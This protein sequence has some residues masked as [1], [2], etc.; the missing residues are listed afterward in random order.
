MMR[1]ILNNQYN[2]ICWDTESGLAPEAL[3]QE[4]FDLEK[5]FEN[6]S[7]SFIKAKTFELLLEK[8]QIAVL[9]E[10]I[11]QEKLNACHIMIRQ[12]LRWWNEASENFK[13]MSVDI[14]KARETKTFTC[15]EDFSHTSSNT[16]MLVDLGFCGLIQKLEDAESK[17]DDITEK[18]KDFYHSSKIAISA[19]QSFCKR[20]SLADGITEENARCLKNISEQAPS[21]FY[22]ALQLI[23]VY[24]YLHEYIAGTR[25]RTLGRLD[26]VLYQTYRKDIDSG[27]LSRESAKECLKYFLNKFWTMKVSY[28][29]PFCLGGIGADGEEITN[30]LSYL[31]VEAYNELNIHS[32]KIHIRVSE[33]TPNSFI[34]LVL[35]CIRGG[36]SSFVFVN[37]AITIKAMMKCGA[38]LEEARNYV[39]IGC[40]E[41]AIFDLEL[42]CTGNGGI[43]LPKMIELVF[44]NGRDFATGELVGV[45]TGSINSYEDFISALKEQ[46][47]YCINKALTYIS[48]VEKYYMQANPDPIL[49]AMLSPC[50]KKGT[51]AYDGG[52]K[53]NNSSYYIHSIATFAD[54]VAAVKKL[55]FDEKRVTFDELGNI[56]KSNWQGHEK[57]RIQMAN[58]NQKY[59]NNIDS[60]DD[61]AVEFA[62]FCAKLI[63]GRANGRGGIFKATNSTTDLCF[64]Y[65]EKTMA[66]PDGRYAGE[67]LSKNLCA[68][69]GKDKKGITGLINT[70][71]KMDLSD[72]PN[73]S[74]LDFV[75]HPSTVQGNDGLDA[76][77]GVLKTYFKKGGMAMHGNVF[78]AEE[79]KRA[80]QNPER[81]ANLQVRVCGWNAYFVNLSKPEQ[82]CFIKQAE[83]TIC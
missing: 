33:K 9:R 74:V 25:V 37:D 8:G 55:V 72:F 36:N 2:E 15:C 51:D 21:N 78:D 68:T 69:T 66:T 46:I 73:G 40:Y 65:G 80:Q 32:P 14:E 57:L 50:V 10:D 35:S 11:F 19:M 64:P 5:R 60:V 30:E 42:P 75:L 76:F 27:L 47:A 45:K 43:N 20:L 24:F 4:V 18:Q 12:R 41:P 54:S 67:P 44:C 22:E 34:K 52:A 62:D 70:V 83:T 16:K 63:N 38:T 79:L 77:Y 23:V 28:D 58:S 1:D 29:L 61:I 3:E 71:T 7:K 59:G 53:Y 31:I 6:Q 13:D 48:T 82:D 26:D 17:I 81:Y 49:S 56:L 39:L